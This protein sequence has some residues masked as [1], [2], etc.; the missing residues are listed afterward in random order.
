MPG[1][2]GRGPSAPTSLGGPTGLPG[3][4]RQAPGPG[5]RGLGG[6]WSRQGGVMPTVPRW[7]RPGRAT[8]RDTQCTEVDRPGLCPGPCPT[9]Q[10]TP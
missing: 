6:P 4:S 3:I 10:T 8:A 2:A 9:P 5:G 1:G 7:G